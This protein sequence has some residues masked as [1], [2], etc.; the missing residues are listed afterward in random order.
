MMSFLVGA[1]STCIISLGFGGSIGGH[2]HAGVDY[3]CGYLTPVYSPYEGLV[4]FRDDVSGSVA[5]IA[6]TTPARL[7]IVGHMATTTVSVG[8]RVGRGDILG[9]EGYKGEAYYRG[10]RENSPAASHRHYGIYLLEEES[11][12]HPE[13]FYIFFANDWF[14]NNRGN[15]LRIKD[16]TSTFD[17]ACD[18]LMCA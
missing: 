12:V 4:I 8:E 14:K 18:P 16:A 13:E 17:G 2:G 1:V 7:F 6:S 15:Y 3:M 10:A 5:L 11:A 9:R